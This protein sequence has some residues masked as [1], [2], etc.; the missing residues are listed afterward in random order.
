M[1]SSQVG[2]AA[3]PSLERELA[4]HRAPPSGTPAPP[5][6][7]GLAYVSLLAL[8]VGSVLLIGA[9]RVRDQSYWG[10][11]AVPAAIVRRPLGGLVRV[12]WAQGAG[13]GPYYAALLGLGR[14]FGGDAGLGN[15]SVLGMAVV[16]AVA[17]HLHRRVVWGRRMSGMCVASSGHNKSCQERVKV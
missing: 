5:S 2:A 10:D 4:P 14:A 8:S 13:S 7:V 17:F 9:G 15:V 11:E 3:E 6:G 16:A 12:L 1:S